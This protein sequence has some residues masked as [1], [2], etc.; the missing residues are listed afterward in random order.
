MEIFYILLVRFLFE[1]EVGQILYTGDFRLCEGD[2]SRLRQLH[3]L[4]GTV[5]VIDKLYLDTTFLSRQYLQFPSRCSSISIVCSLISSWLQEEPD[6]AVYIE[7]PGK[8]T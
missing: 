7:M 8:E 2:A 3:Y 6:N 4:D 5:K 1:G